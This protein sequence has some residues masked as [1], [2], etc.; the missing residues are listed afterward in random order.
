MQTGQGIGVQCTS[1]VSYLYN[2]TVHFKITLKTAEYTGNV[3]DG[4]L[5]SSFSYLPVS[6]LLKKNTV[7]DLLLTDVV[8]DVLTSFVD[9]LPN[10]DDAKLYVTAHHVWRCHF[11]RFSNSLFYKGQIRKHNVH[12]H[13]AV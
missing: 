12:L 4:N 9:P 7:L 2:K 13:I 10:I 8:P 3:P 1:L 11:R 5:I 6:Q